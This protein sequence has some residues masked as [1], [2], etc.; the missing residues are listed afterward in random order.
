MV[1]PTFFLPIRTKSWETTSVLARGS[2]PIHKQSMIHH[3][4]MVLKC[5]CPESGYQTLTTISHYSIVGRDRSK[6]FRTKQIFNTKQIHLLRQPSLCL[7]SLSL[8][9]HY[10]LLVFTR[11]WNPQSQSKM[12]SVNNAPTHLELATCARLSINL[13]EMINHRMTTLRSASR[14]ND[15]FKRVI[16]TSI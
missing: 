14:T 1:L 6:S 2:F 11:S 10:I 3:L 13:I 15:H 9:N 4:P 8:D 5:L 12:P 7:K 16:Y